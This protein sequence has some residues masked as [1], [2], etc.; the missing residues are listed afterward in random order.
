MRWGDNVIC[1]LL[2]LYLK[3]AYL[4]RS[5]RWQL[6]WWW[7]LLGGERRVF[8][9]TRR[10]LQFETET[11]KLHRKNTRYLKEYVCF[12]NFVWEFWQCSSVK[13][14]FNEWAVARSPAVMHCKRYL[15]RKFARRTFSLLCCSCSEAFDCFVFLTPRLFFLSLC[16]LV[17]EPPSFLYLSLP[18]NSSKCYDI[19]KCT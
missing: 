9:A 12:N 11:V 2:R 7:A 8:T 4:G 13:M 19:N 5:C 16:T 6:F 10:F 15:G 14:Q 3:T 18:K 17:S 1:I